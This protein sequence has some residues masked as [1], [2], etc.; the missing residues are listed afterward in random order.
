MAWQLWNARDRWWFEN[1]HQ[2]PAIIWSWALN[3]V[4]EIHQG[5]RGELVRT[6]VYRGATL[7]KPPGLGKLK[8]NSDAEVFSD[9]SVV[10]G[11]VVRTDEGKSV[12]PGTKRMEMA[13]GNNVLMEALAL[14]F[15]VMVARSQGFQIDTLE[16]DSKSL[17]YSL[18]GWSDADASSMLIVEDIDIESRV[19]DDVRREP[20]NLV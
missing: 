1:E 19:L 7:W 15:G 10:L 20:L 3:M 17:V 16:T 11:F 12:L 5:S 18:Q 4:N 9:G 2:S 6:S 8:I 14:H 13:S